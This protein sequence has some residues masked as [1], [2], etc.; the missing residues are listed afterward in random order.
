[1]TRPI[2]VTPGRRWLA[3]AV[4]TALAAASLTAFTAAAHAA[5]TAPAAPAK[6]KPLTSDQAS[7]QARRTGKA[8]SVDAATTATD[9]LTANAD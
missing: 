1:M 4:T 5:P 7:V 2:S 3:G 6:A 9:E 8:V